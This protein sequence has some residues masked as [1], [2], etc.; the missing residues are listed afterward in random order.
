MCIRDRAE[1]LAGRRGRLTATYALAIVLRIF[2]AMSGTDIAYAPTRNYGR[3]HLLWVSFPICLR[4]CY[5]MSGTD[6]AYG[7]YLSM[8]VL[9]DARY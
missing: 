9:R 5:A 7:P 3:Y 8:R 2:Y 6:V 4:V 1:A